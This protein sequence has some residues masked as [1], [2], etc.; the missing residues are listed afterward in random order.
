M[1]QITPFFLAIEKDETMVPLLTKK[2]PD[3]ELVQEVQKFEE[4]GK[5]TILFLDQQNHTYLTK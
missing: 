3:L 2:I 1:C 5:N 4:Q